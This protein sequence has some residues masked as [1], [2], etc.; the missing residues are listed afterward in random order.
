MEFYIQEQKHSCASNG[1]RAFL[2]LQLA[3]GVLMIAT[4]NGRF[5][6]SNGNSYVS[7]GRSYELCSTGTGLR[8]LL[9]D[10]RVYFLCMFIFQRAILISTGVFL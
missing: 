5:Y 1:Q 9:C 10:K 4:G 8:A 6:V 7:N 3:T 2:C